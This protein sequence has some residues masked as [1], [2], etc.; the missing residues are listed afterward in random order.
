MDLDDQA[1]VVALSEGEDGGSSVVAPP[2]VKRRRIGGRE[3]ENMLSM[4]LRVG[5]HGMIN[6]AVE[7][8]LLE[9]RQAVELQAMQRSIREGI[10][11]LAHMAS[12]ALFW[13]HEFTSLASGM[14]SKDSAIAAI[15]AGAASSAIPSV[16]STCAV[17]SA[18]ASKSGAVSVN[19]DTTVAQ[20]ASQFASRLESSNV[21]PSITGVARE[22]LDDKYRTV[23][24][25]DFRKEFHSMVRTLK[26]DRLESYFLK[27]E[28]LTSPLKEMKVGMPFAKLPDHLWFQVLN[29]LSFTDILHF[30]SGIS[31]FFFRLCMSSPVWGNLV[32]FRFGSRLILNEH[33]PALIAKLPKLRLVKFGKYIRNDKMFELV[34][35]LE[36]RRHTIEA[37]NFSTGPNSVADLLF[38]SMFRSPERPWRLKDINLSSC[39]LISDTTLNHISSCCPEL[40]NLNLKLCFRISDTGL[41]FLSK[42]CPRLEVLTLRYCVSVTDSGLKSLSEG[43]PKLHTVSFRNCVQMTNAGVRYLA[44]RCSLLRVSFSKCYRLSDES[45]FELGS[46]CPSLQYAHFSFCNALT[47]VGVVRL[48]SLCKDLRNIDLSMC[49]GITDASIRALAEHCHHLEHVCLK[50]CDSV[51]Q[52]ATQRLREKCPSLMKLCLLNHE[53]DQDEQEENIANQEEAELMDIL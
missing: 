11:A 23:H 53:F 15:T 14:A 37:L 28:E 38:Q 42:G 1:S 45:L 33:I 44:S 4:E 24:A 27:F 49:R 20:F 12:G 3:V 18:P 22:L 26:R 51:T 32:A 41:F 50:G 2:L 19:A 36:V 13:N 10:H 9:A 47:D 31:R 16:S 5:L 25:S 8:S 21:I 40:R 6:I 29:M 17:A 46:S 48:A 30:C 52:E 34:G 35:S 43:C 39:K 7:D